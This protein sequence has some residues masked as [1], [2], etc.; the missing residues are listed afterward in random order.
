[1]TDNEITSFL[2]DIGA[3]PLGE[4]V[5]T[6]QSLADGTLYIHEDGQV[7]LLEGEN[8]RPIGNLHD[9]D[10]TYGDI[11]EEMLKIGG[12]IFQF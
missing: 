9:R 4:E 5:I 11:F 3:P 12:F 1:M 10:C 7:D 8:V 6:V 2:N